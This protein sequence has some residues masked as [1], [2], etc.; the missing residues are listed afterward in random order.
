MQQQL[1][2]LA[3]HNLEEESKTSQDRQTCIAS[4]SNHILDTQKLAYIL[5]TSKVQCSMQCLASCKMPS[6][7]R[8]T[9]SSLYFQEVSTMT[10]PAFQSDQV[11]N[12]LEKPYPAQP[13]VIASSGHVSRWLDLVK[14]E[15]S[16]C[17]NRATEVPQGAFQASSLAPLIT[18]GLIPVF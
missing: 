8:Q 18:C 9:C 12:K 7:F 1:Y 11:S 2:C 3:L 10:E 5:L 13:I 6:H 16:P 14:I 4:C 17:R 15:Q